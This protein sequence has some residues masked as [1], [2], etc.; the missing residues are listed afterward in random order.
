MTYLKIINLFLNTDNKYKKIN[1]MVP[2]DRFYFQPSK[3]VDKQC[4]YPTLELTLN[5]GENHIS[6][7]NNKTGMKALL[8]A[9][10][11]A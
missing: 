5:D 6:I 9:H 1:N 8:I 11:N 2:L 10:G 4:L 3:I 7:Y